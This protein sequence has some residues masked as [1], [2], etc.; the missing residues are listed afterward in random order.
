MSELQ[1][2]MA[3]VRSF[4]AEMRSFKVETEQRF[5][6]VHQRFDRADARMDAA[7][8]KAD[9]QHRE[10]ALRFDKL[11]H[12]VLSVERRFSNEITTLTEAVND[13]VFAGHRELRKR[14]ERCERDIDELKRR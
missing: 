2:F 8:E 4:M 13:E 5:E 7:N 3:D 14:I 11:D 9:T 10:N 6:K 1:T 12:H